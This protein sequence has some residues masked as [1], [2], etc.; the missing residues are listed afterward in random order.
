MTDPDMNAQ[1]A[2]LIRMAGEIHQFFRRQGDAA[3]AAAAHHMQQFWAPTMRAD[4][5]AVVAGLTSDDGGKDGVPLH[6]IAKA[7]AE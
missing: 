5:V 6:A 2:K 1:D 7:L 3:P 4:F